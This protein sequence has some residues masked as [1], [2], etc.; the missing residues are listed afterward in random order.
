MLGL[1]INTVGK[2]MEYN[3]FPILDLS[4]TS[5]AISFVKTP[6]ETTFASFQVP[7]IRSF[8]AGGN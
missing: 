6:L 3:C 2:E 8:S 1:P 5:I 4:S 7:L